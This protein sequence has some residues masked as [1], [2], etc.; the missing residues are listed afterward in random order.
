[1][2][3]R[4][5]T[6]TGFKS[7]ANKTVLDLE[8]GITGVVGPNGSG[9][10]NL[11]DAVRWALGEQSK[12]RLRLTER[13]HIVFA[14]T[15]KRPRASYAEVVLLFNN[16]DGTFPLDLT[17]VE[18]S[19]RLYRS[20]ETD[21]RLAGRSV[22]LSDIQALLAQAGF[23]TNTYTVIGQGMI[24]SF[25]LS[26]PAD[27]KLLFDEAAGIRGPE[28]GREAARRKLAATTTNLTRLRDI[29]AELAPRLTSL[30]TAV[31]AATEQRALEA[32]VGRLRAVLSATADLHWSRQ[33][34]AATEQLR[35]L[36]TTEHRLRHQRTK[37]EHQ[38]A[39]ELAQETALAA[40]RDK[41]QAS[42]GALEQERDQ[43]GLELSDRRAAITAAETAAAQATAAARHLTEARGDLAEA[44]EHQ[45]ELMAE[46][47]SNTAAADRALRAVERTGGEVAKAQ[48]ALVALRQSST[49]GTRDQY[50]DHALQILKT[51]AQGLGT[52]EISDEQVRLLVHKAGRLLSHATRTGAA[53]LL[54]TLQTAQ[55]QLET[56]MGKRETAVEHQTNIT[57]T[58]RSLEID[59]A[60]QQEAARRVE[61]TVARHEAELATLEAAAG[62]LT[63]AQDM[64][65]AAALSFADVTARLE[66]Q[67]DHIRELSA[68]ATDAARQTQLA[69]ELERAKSSLQA[70]ANEHTRLRHEQD[71]AKAALR[72][73]RRQATQWGVDA[74][75]PSATQ[76]LEEL[77]ADLLRAEATLEAKAAAVQAQTTE[78]E[79]VNTR[80]AELTTQIADLESAQAD[81]EGVITELD[82]LIKVRFKENFQALSA[83][84][85]TYFER[86]FGGGSASLELDEGEDGNYGVA[87]KANPKGKR[88]TQ[89]A[90]LSGGE[91][92][93]AGVALLAA[94]LRVN[95]SP[96]VVLDEVDAALDEANS[97]RLADILEELGAHSQLII[98]THNHQTMRAA[99]VLFGITANEH[100]ASHLISL[101]LEEATAL[102]AR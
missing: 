95:P 6:I 34:V 98:I 7:F 93:L 84:F 78:Y 29:A 64:A 48:A 28:L 33:A 25:L 83:Q 44:E 27:R 49:E 85:K 61:Q 46:L 67:R 55:K 97:T 37:L 79:E 72:A 14:G 102:A 3:L 26:S 2:F 58:R 45:S 1:M 18:I 101:R 17:E 81:L 96:F 75:R 4:R 91:R 21:Y 92:A 88:L 87:I 52:P 31:S 62:R 99:R 8:P 43:L 15:E 24:D 42:L 16:E 71:A 94:I 30:Q 63:Q 60:H 20:G 77:R 74:A 86:L 19:R 40:S 10:S 13:E 76:P 56:A 68:T 41:L 59:L 100:H 38:L 82:A 50:V 47:A 53:E 22:R 54:A 73:A 57:I 66:Q 39:K 36:A 32:R 89:L 9:K 12:G 90:S 69:T 5:V 80:H 11:A 70:T 35:H 51:L 65:E 23:G